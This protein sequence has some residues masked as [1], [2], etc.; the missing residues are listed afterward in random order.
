M[1]GVRKVLNP[2]A[3]LDDAPGQRHGLETRYAG[4]KRV[5][6]GHMLVVS[7]EGTRLSQYWSPLD[8]SS[9]IKVT[10]RDCLE[11]FD[12]VYGQAV[13]SR[14]HPGPVATQL[15][16]GLDSS[17]IKDLAARSLSAKGEVLHSYTAA[18]Q[19][20]TAWP[21]GGMPLLGVPV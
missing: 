15:S 1:P 8:V 2:A 11:Q 4:I 6:P 19:A 12:A 13:K 9:K 20:G 7:A 5:P 14:L 16:A 18:L 10:D 3:V 21:A 17:T